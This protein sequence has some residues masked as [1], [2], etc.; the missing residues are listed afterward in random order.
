MKNYLIPLVLLSTVF[1][2]SNDSVEKASQV[3]KKWAQANT[4][5]IEFELIWTQAE[6]GPTSPSQGLVFIKR[7][8]GDRLGAFKLI[9]SDLEIYNTGVDYY[10]F[11]PRT[12]QLVIK[13][14]KAGVSNLGIINK[15]L[16]CDVKDASTVGQ[17]YLL[18]LDVSQCAPSLNKIEI[19]ISSLSLK[20]SKI[21]SIKTHD[22]SHNIASYKLITA[23]L[24]LSMDEKDFLPTLSGD[25]DTLDL[26]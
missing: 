17:N 18:D 1:A 24:S 11:R 12:E 23:D 19:I 10:E 15:Y 25:I 5:K 13:P 4:V 7:P 6:K 22:V 8:Q 14:S 9:T 21:L 3:L 16:S 26:R 2:N 20:D